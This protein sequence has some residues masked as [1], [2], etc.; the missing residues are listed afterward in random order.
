MEETHR[1]VHNV[2]NNWESIREGTIY[3]RFIKENVQTGTG[4][5]L[6]SLCGSYQKEEM[7]MKIPTS[8]GISDPR[9]L[10]RHHESSLFIFKK[11]PI[12]KLKMK[13]R[14]SWRSG[15]CVFMRERWWP[16]PLPS[17]STA[18]SYLL[19]S[20]GEGKVKTREV[21]CCWHLLQRIL[22]WRPCYLLAMAYGPQSK[23]PREAF[24]Q[25]RR[26]FGKESSPLEAIRELG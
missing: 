16:R 8:T 18:V 13:R 24:G 23:W 2:W 25:E 4:S 12:K 5:L 10:G 21:N 7:V 6:K 26:F 9:L 1:H 19:S 17:L 15:S 3:W 20:I 11:S 22:G 14:D